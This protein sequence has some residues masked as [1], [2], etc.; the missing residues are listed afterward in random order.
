[1]NVFYTVPYSKKLAK[2]IMAGLSESVTAISSRGEKYQNFAVARDYYCPAV[3]CEL[4]FICNPYEYEN[5]IDVVSQ[6]R[7]VAGIT[8]GIIKYFE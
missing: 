2:N 3:L 5:I 4:G 1:M 6:S 8:K 7:V